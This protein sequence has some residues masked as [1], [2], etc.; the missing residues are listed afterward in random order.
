MQPLVFVIVVN[1]NQKQLTLECLASL[2]KVEYPA[3]RLLLVDNGS[4]DGSAEAI[5]ETFPGVQVLETGSNLLF[6]GGN[7][8]GMRIAMSSGADYLIL[9]NNDTLVDQGF[10]SRL[11]ERLQ[12]DPLCGIVAPK[13][14]Y[15]GEPDRLWFAGGAVSL[16]TGTMRH[17]GIRETDRGQHDR[18][19]EIGYASGCCLMIRRSVVE[20]IG[21]LDKAYR[22]YGE[23]A[24]WCMRARR[25]GYTIWYEPRAKV[26]HRVSVS[27]GGHLSLFKQKHKALSNIRFFFRYAA[28]YQIPAV[29]VLAPLLNLAAAVR[30]LLTARR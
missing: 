29:I 20:R 1:W 23:D 10:V 17:I 18:P 26:W 6:A 2:A 12:Q 30:F 5:R 11:V 8:A 14:L 22:M 21:M 3:I 25:A 19:R 7:N 24:D 13:I 16:W 9:L 15:A 4:T 28:W 27:A